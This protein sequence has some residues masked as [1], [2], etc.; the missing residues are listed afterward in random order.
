MAVVEL[1]STMLHVNS[2]LCNTMCAL[3]KDATFLPWPGPHDRHCTYADMHTRMMREIDPPYRG[4][5][6][7]PG[8]SKVVSAPHARVERLSIQYL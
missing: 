6:C 7:R 8:P 3:P 2:M 1:H 4:N 5:K